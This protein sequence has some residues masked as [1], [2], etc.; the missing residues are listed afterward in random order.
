MT[1]TFH[2]LKRAG[3]LTY[4]YQRAE[5]AALVTFS[6]QVVNPCGSRERLA[7]LLEMRLVRKRVWKP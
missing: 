1:D 3:V 6:P 5:N 4:G 2:E 7:D